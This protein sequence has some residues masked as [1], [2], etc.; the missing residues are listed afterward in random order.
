MDLKPLVAVDEDNLAF[1]R[2]LLT[3]LN[4]AAAE[5]S[6]LGLTAFDNINIGPST[7]WPEMPSQTIFAIVKTL[8]GIKIRLMFDPPAN[9]VIYNT[10]DLSIRTHEGRLIDEIIKTEAI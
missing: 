5:L 3:Y 4:S 10:L 8:L 1:D 7:P 9:Q 6:Q 2:E